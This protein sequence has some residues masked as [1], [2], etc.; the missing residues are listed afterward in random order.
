MMIAAAYQMGGLKGEQIGMAH[1]ADERMSDYTRKIFG[2][3]CCN[4]L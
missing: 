2:I 3:G 4:A 1:N